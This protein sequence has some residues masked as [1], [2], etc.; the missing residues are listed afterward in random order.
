MSGLNFGSFGPGS[1]ISTTEAITG[2][3]PVDSD[4][5][6]FDKLTGQA[7]TFKQQQDFNA[8]QASL[9][10]EFNKSEAEKAREFSKEE[11]QK[12][13]DFEERMSN[14]AY[15]RMMADAKEAG[16]NPLNLIGASGA[17]V[18]S[19]SPASASS[20][21]SSSG[22]RSSFNANNPITTLSSAVVSAMSVMMMV[23]KLAT[24]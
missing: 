14:T 3:Q 19:G 13:R 22:A 15:Q 1:A 17:S 6:W 23:A 21:A 5:G 2:L 18:P 10:R 20:A 8:Y 4:F 24:L 9:E 16:I 11:A 12:A 7:D